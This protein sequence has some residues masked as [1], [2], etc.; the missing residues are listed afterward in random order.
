[1]P[2]L[3]IAELDQRASSLFAKGLADSTKRAYRCGQRRYL[4]FCSNGNL[5]AIPATERVLSYFV[6]QLAKEGLRHKTIKA[7]LS[8]VRFL[9]ISK[10]GDDPFWTPLNRLHYILQGI[11]REEANKGVRSR[12]RLPISPSILR[13]IKAVWQAQGQNPDTIMLW[14][15]VCLGFFAFLRAGEMTVP[16]DDGLDLNTHLTPQDISVDCPHRPA[17]MKVTIKTSKTDP[18]RKGI[19]LFLGKSETDLCPV[20]AVLGYLVVRGHGPGPLFKFKDGCS[21]T[22][23]RLVVAVREALQVAGLDCTKYCGHSFRIGAATMAA[24]KEWRM[25]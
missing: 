21:L 4:R 11:R 16:S 17:V 2:R 22:R 1:M 3:D 13:T 12:E 14:A 20:V 24:K 5:G 23:Q 10:G 15:A 19:D 18:F 7:Y 25:Q 9:H 8:A 6:T